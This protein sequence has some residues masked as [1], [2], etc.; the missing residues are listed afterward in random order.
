MSTGAASARG[1]ACRGTFSIRIGFDEKQAFLTGGGS[2]FSRAYLSL[3]F[4]IR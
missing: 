2:Y 3:R 1:G 4:L